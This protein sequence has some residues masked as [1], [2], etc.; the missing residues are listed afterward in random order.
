MI[1]RAMRRWPKSGMLKAVLP[2]PAPMQAAAPLGPM[3]KQKPPG[4]S[5]LGNMF[6]FRT[7][8]PVQ[9]GRFTP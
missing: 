3:G 5:L 7:L 8:T 1:L 6:L 4:A 9:S 2:N